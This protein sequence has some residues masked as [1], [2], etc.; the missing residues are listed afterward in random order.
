MLLIIEFF[1]CVDFLKF[2]IIVHK[3]WIFDL[4]PVICRHFYN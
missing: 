4:V 3:I 1:I 2:Q